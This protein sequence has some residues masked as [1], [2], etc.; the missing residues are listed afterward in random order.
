MHMACAGSGHD[1]GASGGCADAVDVSGWRVF[2]NDLNRQSSIPLGTTYG[3]CPD[4]SGSFE[5]TAASA[6][7]T[8]HATLTIGRCPD[9]KCAFAA[10]TSSTKGA[11][12][13]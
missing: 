1:E 7:W 12:N 10:T 6:S 8:A 3:R 13:V 5:T 2:D 11:P 9:G 4:P